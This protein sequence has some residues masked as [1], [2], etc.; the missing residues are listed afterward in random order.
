MTSRRNA[1]VVYGQLLSVIFGPLP[2]Q[3][4]QLRFVLVSRLLLVWYIQDR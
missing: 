4:P 3:P 1:H 2:R